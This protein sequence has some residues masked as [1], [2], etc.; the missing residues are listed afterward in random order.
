MCGRWPSAGNVR[1]QF[2]GTTQLPGF[3]GTR[4]V[5]RFWPGRRSVGAKSRKTYFGPMSDLLPAGAKV[6][7]ATACNRHPILR[8]L[9]PRLPT[10][11]IVLEI[12]AGAGEHAVYNAA[13]FPAL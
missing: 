2:C 6:S 3:S 11:G 9:K 13:A 10:A 4:Y 7:P 8:V 12:A 1:R 5:D